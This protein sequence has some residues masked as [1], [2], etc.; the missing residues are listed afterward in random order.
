MIVVLVSTVAG[1]V[2]G[3]VVA[4]RVAWL[5]RLCTPRRQMIDEV[6]S[7]ARSVFFDNRIHRTEGGTGL[8]VYISLFEHQAALI[9]DET[10]TE[11]LGQTALDELCKELTSALRGGDIAEAIC[12]S[13][14]S[15]GQRLGEVLPRQDDDV[16]ELPDSLVTL[17]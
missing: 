6:Q 3:A 9:A 15:A 17:D 16:N 13:M 10:V 7:R 11:K 8:L 14:V 1:F 12:Q 5:R 2:A 4:S